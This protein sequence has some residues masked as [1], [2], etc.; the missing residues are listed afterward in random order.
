MDMKKYDPYCVDYAYANW[1]HVKDY[2]GFVSVELYTIS[3]DYFSD[4]IPTKYIYSFIL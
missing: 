2:Y 4:G 3:N 1:S